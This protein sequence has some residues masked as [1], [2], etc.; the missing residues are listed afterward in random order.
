MPVHDTLNGDKIILFKLELTTNSSTN[1]VRHVPGRVLLEGLRIN[2]NASQYVV[3]SPWEGGNKS[4]GG[5]SLFLWQLQ[6]DLTDLSSDTVMLADTSN[7][8]L[9]N[10]YYYQANNIV[11]QNN[12]SNIIISAGDVQEGYGPELSRA[13]YPTNVRPA[14]GGGGGSFYEGRVVGFMPQKWLNGNGTDNFA[15]I[16]H[17][18]TWGSSQVPVSNKSPHFAKPQ[19]AAL[20][21]LHVN[22]QNHLEWMQ[23]FNASMEEG[24][25]S[26]IDEGA[27]V[28]TENSLHIIYLK[29]IKNGRQTLGD[30]IM[31]PDGQ[32]ETKP[33]ISMNLKS[34]YLLD[35]SLQV[36]ENVLIIPCVINDKLSFAKLILN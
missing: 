28:V 32:Y 15:Q 6:K 1:T 34:K 7:S 3:T 26:L 24:F 9:Q 31:K 5:P 19:A 20:A 18:P 14:P 25:K 29:T 27:F 13:S 36:D 12:S 33:I 8:C 21:I 11:L 17:G 35:Q 16:S 23:C 30:L 22:D 4:G 10:I 2:G